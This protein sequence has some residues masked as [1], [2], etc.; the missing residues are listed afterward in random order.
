VT[1]D[2]KYTYD[3]RLYTEYVTI[4]MNEDNIWKPKMILHSTQL[5]NGDLIMWP[6]NDKDIGGKPGTNIVMKLENLNLSA[7]NKNC[8][9]SISVGF[10]PSCQVQVCCGEGCCCGKVTQ[11]KK[12]NGT[13]ICVGSVCGGSIYRICCPDG[14]QASCNCRRDPI[15]MCS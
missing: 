9:A 15:C 5:K 12:V 8:C 4:A 6:A 14:K 10:P 11:E 1:K 7:E 13:N 2:Y 3:G